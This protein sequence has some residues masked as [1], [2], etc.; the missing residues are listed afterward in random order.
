MISPFSAPR[1]ATAF[2]PIQQPDS[3]P[4]D[5]TKIKAALTIVPWSILIA[6]TLFSLLFP[7]VAPRLALPALGVSA[8]LFGMPHGACDVAAWRGARRWNARIGLFYGLAALATFG[9]WRLSAP[10]GLCAFLALTLWHWG[11]GDA[12]FAFSRPRARVWAALGR[13]AIL[14]AAPL[15]FQS[16]ASLE[17]LQPLWSL[18][19]EAQSAPL[20]LSSLAPIVVGAGGLATL[21]ALHLE[22]RNSALWM[23]ETLLILAFWAC[24]PPLLGVALYLS[25]VHAARHLMRLETRGGREKTTR[26]WLQIAARWHREGAFASL[27][28]LLI[29]P[30]ALKFWPHLAASAGGWGAAYLV[31]IAALTTPHALT[32]AWLARHQQL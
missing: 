22:S 5:R 20:F 25:G 7:Q 9:L 19:K 3:A 4:S 26:S 17:V 6:A 28:A 27:L 32:V 12:W 1:E 11:E 2:A 8:L 29:L 10:L 30:V 23:I 15:A 31:L 13:G 14:M 16:R 21:W 18:G 24:V